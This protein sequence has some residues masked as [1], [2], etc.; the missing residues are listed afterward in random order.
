MQ[1][2]VPR[3]YYKSKKRTISIAVLFVNQKVFSFTQ[4]PKAVPAKNQLYEIVA[5]PFIGLHCAIIFT[6][7][8][9]YKVCIS[10]VIGVDGQWGR[11]GWEQCIMG[12][13]QRDQKV[14]LRGDDQFKM[15]D[16]N[17]GLF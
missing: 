15:S 9:M 13:L 2:I 16:K 8:V 7:P 14:F 5:E 12:L 11:L 3:L 17:G 1:Y 6:A 10:R 4:S